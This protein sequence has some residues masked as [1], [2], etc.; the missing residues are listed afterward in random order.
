MQ[1]FEDISQLE[2][3]V[4]FEEDGSQSTVFTQMDSRTTCTLH[5][6]TLKKNR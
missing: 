2:G 3:R 5:M 1:Y 4:S 6:K